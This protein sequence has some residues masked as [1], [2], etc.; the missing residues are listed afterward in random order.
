LP[1][2]VVESVRVARERCVADANGEHVEIARHIRARLA[3]G[4]TYLLP[5]LITRAGSARR[6]LG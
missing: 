6:F 1:P 2:L 4:Q 5:E 3:D